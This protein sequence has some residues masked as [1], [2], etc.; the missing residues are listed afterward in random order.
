MRGTEITSINTGLCGY[1]Q[2]F[3]VNKRSMLWLRRSATRCSKILPDSFERHLLQSYKKCISLA[4]QYLTIAI[5]K[6]DLDLTLETS[7]I[8]CEVEVKQMLINVNSANVWLT[9]Q[10]RF[11]QANFNHNNRNSYTQYFTCVQ[12]C[13]FL[14]KV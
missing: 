9:I 10:F 11:E 5:I 14:L 13:F 6:H 8:D 12:T 3:F 1:R 4:S 2:L 7:F